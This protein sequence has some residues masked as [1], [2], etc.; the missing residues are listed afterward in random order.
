M[1]RRALLLALA[2]GAAALAPAQMRVGVQLF[3]M[4]KVERASVMTTEELRELQ[5]EIREEQS[6][7]RRAFAAVK[8]DWDKQYA[9]ARKAGD[10]D[11]PKFPTKAF[12]W[13]RSVK[14]RNFS[15]QKAA[16][17]WLAKQQARIDA[18]MAALAGARA[19]QAKASSAAATAG[20]KSRD[21]RKARRQAEKDELQ[22]ALR[23][24]LGEQ[25]ELQMAALLKYNR[26]VPRHFVIDPLAG[27]NTAGGVSEVGKQAAR[28]EAALKAYRERK[29]AA[30]AEA[31]AGGAATP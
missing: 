9:E 29:A 22:A 25:V 31:A 26:P 19:R 28:Q 8:R 11:F 10:K 15:T 14:T 21:D 13:P 12:I 20:Y 23:E 4:Y 18:E 7:F 17:E 24:K 27:V 6:V 1:S 3:D 30:E 2:L 5:A 16:D